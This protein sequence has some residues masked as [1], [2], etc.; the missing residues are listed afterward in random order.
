MKS[1]VCVVHGLRY[2]H[3]WFASGYL[4]F[5]LWV[6]IGW[7]QPQAQGIP[8]GCTRKCRNRHWNF[9]SMCSTLWLFFTPIN[10]YSAEKSRH[11]GG[12]NNLSVITVEAVHLEDEITNGKKVAC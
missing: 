4:A 3:F 7:C 1:Q 12:L 9:M 10:H 2:F 6:N 5:P 11:L 8:F